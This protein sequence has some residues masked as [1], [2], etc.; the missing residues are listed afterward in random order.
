MN[1]R[2]K[3]IGSS[4]VVMIVCAHFNSIAAESTTTQRP[5]ALHESE[6]PHRKPEGI[7]VTV[8][9]AGSLVPPRVTNPCKTGSCPFA[10]QKVTIL[11]FRGEPISGPVR[12]IKDEFEAATGAKLD[13]V[14]VPFNE[15]FDNFVSDVTNRVGK[16]DATM[17]GAWWLGELVER[18]FIIPYDK[19]YND[20]R[21]PKW[22]IDDILPGPRSLLEYQGK[23]YMV[24]NDHDGQVL[25]FR[26]DL[27]ADSQHKTAF[28]KK[29]HYA[30]A[31]PKT[32]NQFRDIAEYFNGKDLN[33]DG[34]PDY[35]LC[36][37]LKVGEQSMFFFMS[38]SAS[39][40]IGPTNPKLY[41]FDP[42]SMK[43]LVESPGHVRA[44]EMMVEVTKFGPKEMLN[45]DLGKSWD[46]FIGGRAALTFDWGNVGG[47][48]QQEGSTIKGKIGVAHIP[49]TR[50]YY[51]IAQHRWVKAEQPNQVAN[52]TGGS[53]AGVISKYAKAPEATYYLLSL[54]ATPKK[55]LVYA[56]RGWD[57]I[58]PGR[59][60]H[61]L[62]PM[63]T[64]KIEDYMR[65]GWNE[66]DVREYLQAYYENFD[67]KLQMPYLRIPGTF[68]YWRALDVHI[69]EALNGELS[70]EGALKAVAVDFEEITIRLGRERQKR[71]YRT[72]LKF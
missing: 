1:T 61:F 29:Y 39:F 34:S 36:L 3:W 71:S 47:L 65:F 63:G 14:E 35:G 37:P 21:F 19:F 41:W 25:Y 70:P 32:W 16:Y 57:G 66:T 49:G 62:P 50:E 9:K 24:A 15:H 20:S 26:R 69:G 11:V 23:K 18:D 22:D 40:V 38:F 7:D 46:C 53:W 43:P 45:W 72:S 10:G 12:E 31:I 5:V 2:I 68:S 42:R 60:S 44:L 6:A 58:D 30:L 13:I 27:L 33:G 48:A 4:A 67:N 28:Q 51:S 55:S 52:V 56:A 54:M 59:Y 8:V 17:A 64:A